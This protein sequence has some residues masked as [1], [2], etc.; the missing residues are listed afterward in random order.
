MPPFHPC[1]PESGRWVNPLPFGC[2]PPAPG[3]PAQFVGQISL[4]IR[5]ITP[6][7]FRGQDHDDAI[8]KHPGAP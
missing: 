4:L 7:G 1:P 2:L 5:E 8:H 3:C 6:L